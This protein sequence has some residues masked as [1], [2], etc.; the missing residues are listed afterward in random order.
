MDLP[1]ARIEIRKNLKVCCQTVLEWH[2]TGIL[3]CS[4]FSDI[5]Y[6]YCEGDHRLTEAEVNRAAMEFCVEWM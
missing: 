1:G 2:R 4:V 6:K 5:S 3:P